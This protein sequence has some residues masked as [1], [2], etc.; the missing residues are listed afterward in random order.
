M[1]ITQMTDA[2]IEWWFVARRDLLYQRTV[3][4]SV[5][6]SHSDTFEMQILSLV[7]NTISIGVSLSIVGAVRIFDVYV[8]QRWFLN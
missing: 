5:C 7:Q 4:H 3:D 6:A 8:K 1:P 2:N